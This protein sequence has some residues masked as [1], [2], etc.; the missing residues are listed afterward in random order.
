MRFQN[1]LPVAINKITHG[2]HKLGSAKV[3]IMRVFI[4]VL[5]LIF[6]FQSWTK[7]DDIRDFQIEGMSIGDSLLNYMSKSEIVNEIEK[8]KIAYDYLSNEFGE[9]YIY[10]KNFKEYDL[11]SFFVKQNDKDFIINDIRGGIFYDNKIDECYKRQEKTSKELT[12]KFKNAKKEKKD[13]KFPWDPTGKSHSLNI[14]FYFYNGDVITIS[15]AE[16]EK[17]LKVKNGYEDGYS[18]S[19]TRNAVH[20]WQK[21]Y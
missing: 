15:C 6:S 5:V 13:L 2:L 20:D 16:Y 10:S 18:L 1:G 19:I 4:T 21:N 7:A 9:V 11:V 17:T 8:N 3:F 14:E 12:L